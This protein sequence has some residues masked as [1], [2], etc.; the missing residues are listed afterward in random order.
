[1]IRTFTEKEEGQEEGL[2][3]AWGRVDNSGG[4]EMGESKH[5][6]RTKAGGGGPRVTGF[7]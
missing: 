5:R 3:G 1:M 6:G 4:T 2:R 7:Y